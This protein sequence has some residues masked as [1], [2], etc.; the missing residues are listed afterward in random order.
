MDLALLRKYGV[1]GYFYQF[2]LESTKFFI[3]G[4]QDAYNLYFKDAVQYLPIENN[5]VTQLLESRDPA[6]HREL[7]KVT[8]LHFLSEKKSWK[9]TTSYPAAILPAMRLYRQY[10][11]AMRT[12]YQLAK[13]V[14]QLTVLVLVDD[15]HDLA[16]CLESI[17]YQDYPNLAVAVLDASSQPAQVYASVAALRQRVLELS[18]Q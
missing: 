4:D 5:Y 9:E 2:I 6:E 13:Q 14:P 12:E 16:R 8:I 17:Y 18:A 15:E 11:Q 3:L 10:R 7:A 1:T